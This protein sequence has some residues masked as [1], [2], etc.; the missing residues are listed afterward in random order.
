MKPQLK[1][2]EHMTM[3]C[4]VNADAL[5]EEITELELESEKP[6]DLGGKPAPVPTDALHVSRE[7]NWD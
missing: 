2:T 4:V 5:C 6:K 1:K 7:F 3:C